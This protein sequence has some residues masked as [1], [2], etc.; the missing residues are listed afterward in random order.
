MLR[1]KL[2]VAVNHDTGLPS[3][4]VLQFVGRR[5]RCDKSSN[6]RTAAAAARLT[7]EPPHDAMTP[8]LARLIGGSVARYL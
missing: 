8:E 2:R 7:D 1:R 5:S 4:K 3:A 6:T